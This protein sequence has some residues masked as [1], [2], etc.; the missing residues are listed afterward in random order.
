M[1]DE[2][3]VIDFIKEN[4]E[5]YFSPDEVLIRWKDRE[6]KLNLTTFKT[7]VTRI[8]GEW[9]STVSQPS[10]LAL[11]W[12]AETK[13]TTLKELNGFLD[14]CKVQTTDT[15][16][17]VIFSDG[18]PINLKDIVTGFNGINVTFVGNYVT[19]WLST[20]KQAL[21][22]DILDKELDSCSVRLGLTEWLVIN[23]EGKVINEK[24]LKKKIA[25]ASIQSIEKHFERWIS[26]KVIEASSKMM[27]E[28]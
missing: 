6:E 17:K 3:L 15:E 14:K 25:W 28:L 5:L 22:K 23:R 19:D 26:D 20:Q 12:F 2:S 10:T 1:T 21:L 24:V 8:F 16:V 27:G 4:F 18:T 11:R 7:C 13:M 9:E